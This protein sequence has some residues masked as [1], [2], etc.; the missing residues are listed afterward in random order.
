MSVKYSF[1]LSYWR[2]STTDWMAHTSPSRTGKRSL[3]LSLG[4]A[5]SFFNFSIWTCWSL[6]VESPGTSIRIAYWSRQSM[7]KDQA[8]GTRYRAMCFTSPV[9]LFSSH[10]STAGSAGWT[11]W[12]AARFMA[13]G[14][15][16]RMPWYSNMCW[17]GVRNGQKLC[18]SSIVP[19]PSI[20]S[21]TATTRFWPRQD[22]NASRR[23]EK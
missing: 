22:R 16:D 17:S 8:S 3:A 5:P 12:T 13:S 14:L 10:P 7:Q 23:K 6:R 11:T 21:K 15:T 1:G 19:A 2:R 9:E 18:P 20:W 4:N